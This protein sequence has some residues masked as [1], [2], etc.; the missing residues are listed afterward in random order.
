M[1]SCLTN[2]DK[3]IRWIMKEN[4]KKKRLVKM[5]SRWVDGWLEEMGK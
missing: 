2:A 5:D 1:E 3:D 4:L